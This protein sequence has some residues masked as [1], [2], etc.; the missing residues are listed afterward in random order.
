MKGTQQGGREPLRLDP[1][2]ACLWCGGQRM[3]LWPK[4]FAVLHYLVAHPG[5]LVTKA[6][7]LDTVWPET[8]VSEGVLNGCI[9][10]IRRTLGD[11]A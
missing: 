10:R 2:N 1:T 4:D 9:R 3:T 5:Q 7:L 8:F 6:E 11:H